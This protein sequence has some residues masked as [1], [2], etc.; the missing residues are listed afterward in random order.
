MRQFINDDKGTDY[1]ISFSFRGS[2]I[3]NATATVINGAQAIVKACIQ[4]EY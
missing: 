4:C 1:I 3:L 2:V